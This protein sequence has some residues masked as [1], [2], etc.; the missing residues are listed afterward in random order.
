MNKLLETY[1]G[2]TVLGIG[3]HPDDLEIGVGGTLAQVVRHGGHVVMAA[4]TIPSMLEER[5]VEARAAAAILG[6]DLE[7]LE[8]ERCRRVED[9]STYQLVARIDALIRKYDPVALF[10]HS[11]HEVHYDHVLVHRAV[12]SSLRLRPMDVYLM[13]PSSCKPTLHA[14][15]A[16][17]W[18]DIGETLE[19]KLQAIA[20]HESQFARRGICLDAFRQMARSQGLPV[21]IAYA[22]GHDIMCLRS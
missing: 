16:R 8:Q 1:A 13:P 10:T 12:L 14:W 19:A 6:A 9:L 22:E 2:K 18:V 4:V 17:I 21:G 7:V 15:Q 20:A 3:A 11:A 5:M